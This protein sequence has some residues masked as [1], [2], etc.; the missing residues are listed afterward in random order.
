MLLG[1][2]LWLP[3]LPSWLLSLRLSFLPPLPLVR[4]LL[5][6]ALVGVPAAVVAL[7]AAFSPCLLLLWF[8]LSLPLWGG[9]CWLRG[10]WL[11]RFVA[12]LLTRS[13]RSC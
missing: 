5:A 8:L 11:A 9:S 7:A 4:R 1:F 6:L 12:W 2:Y 13:L 3:F 10:C